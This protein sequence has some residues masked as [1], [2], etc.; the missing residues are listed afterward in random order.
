MADWVTSVTDQFSS[1][2][3]AAVATISTGQAVIR[4]SVEDLSGLGTATLRQ[5]LNGA[6]MYVDTFTDTLPSWTDTPRRV[7]ASFEDAITQI[8]DG[9]RNALGRSFAAIKTTGADAAAMI[10]TFGAE[11]ERSVI[12]TVAAGVRSATTLGRTVQDSFSNAI[13]QI[14]DGG[15]NA[16]G[17]SFAAIKTTGADAAAMITTF[18]AE[19]ERSVIGTV[20]AG[21]RSATTLGRTVQDSF[22]NAITQIGDGGRNALG[23]SFA[24]IKTTG[25]DAAAMITTFGAE[26]ERSVIGT[27]AAGVRSATTLSR[28]V[29][30]SFSNAVAQIGDGGRNALGRSFAAIKTTGADAAAMITTFGAEAERSVIGTVAAGVRSA[31]TLGRTVQDSFS[32]AVAQIGDSGRNALG[33]SFAAIKTTGADAAAMI[34]TFGAEAERSVIGT[35]AAGVRSATTLGRTVQDSFSNAVAQIGDNGQAMIA[36]F[37]TERSPLAPRTQAGRSITDTVTAGVRD[38]TTLG[39]AARTSLSNAIALERN[40]A[41]AGT[42]ENV[43]NI[44]INFDDLRDFPSLMEYLKALKEET[45]QVASV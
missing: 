39:R 30:D 4:S 20:A 45:D 26:A 11:A 17:R 44:G 27:V 15:R 34:T 31:T 9:G 8:G 29:Q 1:A 14:G 10:T 25:A 37:G 33:R 5:T 23:R 41:G 35:V 38:A 13:T 28:T 6:S 2:W 36:T 7:A 40:G 12:G 22:S 19:A 3:Q 16:L 21:V 18:G 42:T 24:A 43:Y 32:N